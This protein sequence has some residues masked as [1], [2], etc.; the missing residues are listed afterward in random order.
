MDAFKII[1]QSMA[2]PARD[3]RIPSNAI[4]NQCS[5]RDEG[6]QGRRLVLIPTAAVYFLV[7]KAFHL[8]V[9]TSFEH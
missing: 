7:D 3:T 8:R 5:H 9:A 2:R 6:C 4:T 1:S